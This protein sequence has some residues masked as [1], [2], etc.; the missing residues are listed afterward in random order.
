M[1]PHR[2]TNGQNVDTSDFKQA[3]NAFTKVT[4]FLKKCFII[5]LLIQANKLL[6]YA[7]ITHTNLQAS[8]ILTYTNIFF[9]Q[10]S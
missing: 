5:V 7:Q 6:V 2:N 8:L 1:W 10:K 4:S 9:F 3:L